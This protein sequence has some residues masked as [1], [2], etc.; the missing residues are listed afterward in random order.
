M[1]PR[2]NICQCFI[3][4]NPVLSSEQVDI[5]CG[6]QPKEN[7]QPS[8]GSPKVDPLTQKVKPAVAQTHVILASLIQESE[9]LFEAVPPDEDK[10]DDSIMDSFSP[11][12][13]EFPDSDPLSLINIAGDEDQKNKLRLLVHEI[14]DIFSSELLATPADIPPFDFNVNDNRW[15]VPKNRQPLWS[16]STDD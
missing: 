5:T 8:D 13:D 10:I 3:K 4:H 7:L 9:R 15:R 6:C 1:I 2:S 14:E 11:W 12:I 16:K